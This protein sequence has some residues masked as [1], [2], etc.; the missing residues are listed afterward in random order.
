MVW[1]PVWVLG[2]TRV[3]VPAPGPEWGPAGAQKGGAAGG[4]QA[5]PGRRNP[6]GAQ[7][8][9]REGER[10]SGRPPER[11]DTAARPAP[12]YTIVS[13]HPPPGFRAKRKTLR[14]TLG[15]KATL[16][17]YHPYSRLRRALKPPVTAETP[18]PSQ[19]PLPGEPSG[20]CSRAA[21]SRWPPLSD[22]C[23]PLFSRSK[24]LNTRIYTT[25]YL[26]MQEEKGYN[27]SKVKFLFSH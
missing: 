8:R 10:P 16:P 6:R 7:E 3:P 15:R 13:I 24:H 23:F 21:F 18:S 11:S 5:G 19:G 12:G 17:R 2:W 22:E 1:V 9:R 20:P 27:S 4:T 25:N 14:P 26:V